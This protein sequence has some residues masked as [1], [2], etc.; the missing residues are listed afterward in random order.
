MSQDLEAMK[1]TITQALRVALGRRKEAIRERILSCLADHVEQELNDLAEPPAL[2]DALFEQ[3]PAMQH[4]GAMAAPAAPAPAN[5]GGLAGATL[6]LSRSADQVSIL[7]SLI[8]GAAK[9]CGRAAVFVCRNGQAMGWEQSGF[10]ANE[11]SMAI[12]GTAVPLSE[13]SA[14]AQ[15]VNSGESLSSHDAEL[16]APVWK[17]IG[18]EASTSFTAI[19]LT[20]RGRIAAVLFADAGE[21]GVVQSEALDV[22]ARMAEMSLETLT[23]RAEQGQV[24]A[25]PATQAE[26]PPAQGVAPAPQPQASLEAMQPTITPPP[27]MMPPP[28]MEEAAQPAF[29]PAME[30]ETPQPPAFTAEPV[31]EPAA[32]SPEE[33][34]QPAAPEAAPVCV[35]DPEEEELHEQARRFARLLISEIVLYNPD[36]VQEGRE[37]HDLAERLREDL[38]RSEEMYRKRVAPEVAQETDY[39]HEEVV[40][41][42]AEG[43]PALMGQ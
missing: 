34:A 6:K 39:F 22:L 17:A 1:E 10:S 25:T 32:E 21:G 24:S 26:A 3:L 41:T 7:E 19:P 5:W 38:E 40:R 14:L 36:A 27:P 23:L 13:N 18:A 29:T 20:V 33:S 12:R 9:F 43:D 15:V 30:E 16:A 4:D 8:E 11:Y 42:L 35:R 37:H 2:D 31:D 28:A